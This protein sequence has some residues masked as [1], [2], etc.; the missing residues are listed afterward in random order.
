MDNSFKRHLKVLGNQAIVKQ[1]LNVRPIQTVS[2]ITKGNGEPT[3]SERLNL[4]VQVSEGAKRLP[5]AE[6]QRVA[7]LIGWLLGGSDG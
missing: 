2:Q 4:L 6:L 7:N 5:D 3:D 1:D